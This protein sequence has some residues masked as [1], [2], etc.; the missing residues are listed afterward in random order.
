MESD[1]AI[2]EY[3]LGRL[4]EGEQERLEEAI[5]DDPDLF[6]AMRAAEG[7]LVDDAAGGRLDPADE[8]A[9]AERGLATRSDIVFSRALEERASRHN[10]VPLRSRSRYPWMAAAAIVV[11]A[12]GA[13]LLVTRDRPET[14]PL[15]AQA[16]EA[17]PPVT[18]APSRITAPP[19]TTAPPA[20][21]V[22]AVTL[23]L[24]GT[25]SDG[26][27]AA[28][29][30]PAGAT[31]VELSVRLHPAESFDRYRIELRS[32]MGDLLWQSETLEPSPEKV[33][34]ASIP[35]ER[36]PEGRVEVVVTAEGDEIGFEPLEVRRIP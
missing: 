28:L 5:F 34:V 1:R 33:L 10:V 31:D 15:V 4:P 16:P 36:V 8:A 23:T 24:G 2:R 12:A 3:L 26:G 35:P 6:D 21:T 32:R 27:V 29:E 9:F 30:I 14:A 18:G 11:V 22:A 20:V 7:D 17:Q 19:V 25:R 13:V